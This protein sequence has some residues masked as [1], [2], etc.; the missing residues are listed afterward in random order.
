[1]ELEMDWFN[2]IQSNQNI[3]PNYITNE[4]PLSSKT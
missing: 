3:L 2:R 1:M 4:V